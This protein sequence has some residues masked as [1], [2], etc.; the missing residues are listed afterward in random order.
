MAKTEN[1][2]VRVETYKSE[3]AYRKGVEKMAELGYGPSVVL[4][5]RPRR[6]WPILLG[7]VG[8]WIV[9]PRR[10][11]SV[12]YTRLPEPWP[13]QSRNQWADQ[14]PGDKRFA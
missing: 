14:R 4:L 6:L 7:I 1:T 13:W 10:E 5:N 8:Y 9:P 2:N 12:T 3:K 11:W